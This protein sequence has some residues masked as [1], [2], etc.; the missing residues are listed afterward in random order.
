MHEALCCDVPAIVSASAGISERY[1][2]ALFDLILRD[3]NDVDELVERLLAWRSR[4]DLWK[5]LVKPFGAELRDRKWRA[6]A[7]D[8][9]EFADCSRGDA[10]S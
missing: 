9:V 2:S 4:N 8:L 10:T 5:E 1:P 7:R 3:P 6:M